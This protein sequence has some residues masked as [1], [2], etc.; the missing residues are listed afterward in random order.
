MPRDI[1][2]DGELDTKNRIKA[3]IRQRSIAITPD[4]IV[5]YIYRDISLEDAGEILDDMVRT[6]K[7][8]T[9]TELED[10]TC[11]YFYK[12]RKKKRYY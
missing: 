12:Y 1:F 2:P 4:I 10:G 7:L 6:E 8:I 3:F 11:A 5:K 9:K